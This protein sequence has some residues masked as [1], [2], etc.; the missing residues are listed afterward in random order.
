MEIDEWV[1]VSNKDLFEATERF[2]IEDEN[3]KRLNL[4][5]YLSHKDEN[6]IEQI[7]NIMFD[8]ENP[9]QNDQIHFGLLDKKDI[10]KIIGL[11]KDESK[12]LK[13]NL[14]NYPESDFFY[15]RLALSIKPERDIVFEDVEIEIKLDNSS[16]EKSICYSMYPLKIEDSNEVEE[17]LSFSAD[18]KIMKIINPANLAYKVKNS[19]KINYPYVI[20]YN[21]G[22]DKPA[23]AVKKTISHPILEGV[24]E[25]LLVIKQPKNTTTN[26]IVQ[27]SG[28]YKQLNLVSKFIFWISRKRVIPGECTHINQ[29]EPSFTIE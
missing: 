6:I 20:G 18:L 4:A 2:E 15:I 26:A 29:L 7:S 5:R 1:N 24:Q 22:T 28:W 11:S 19:F 17:E 8:R 3:E 16:S 12:L 23:W 25:L 9:T 27:L 14:K 13:N 21:L 10:Q